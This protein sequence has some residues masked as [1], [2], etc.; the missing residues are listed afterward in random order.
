LANIG[1][2]FFI[3]KEWL[4]F[5]IPD[6][7]FGISF[8]K[9]WAVV[10]DCFSFLGCCLKENSLRGI[11]YKFIV[12]VN[13]KHHYCGYICV[14]S[15]CACCGW[16]FMYSFS[17]NH[18]SLCRLQNFCRETEMH[19]F[20]FILGFSFFFLPTAVN[21]PTNWCFSKSISH[22]LQT[23]WTRHGYRKWPE[24]KKFFMR[25]LIIH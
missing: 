17:S 22:V 15:F 8:R 5:I 6:V 23:F 10:L 25:N 21:G 11:Y 9:K 19:N 12:N 16:I 7:W 14:Y 4:R 13:I 1:F 18:K 2:F 3:W 20:W 24:K